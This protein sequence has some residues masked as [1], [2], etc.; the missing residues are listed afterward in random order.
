MLLLKTKAGFTE[1]PPFMNVT[2]LRI[3]TIKEFSMGGTQSL[4][5]ER[6]IHITYTDYTLQHLMEA[7]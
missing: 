2:E 6:D 3:K 7:H 5:T 1:S 4:I